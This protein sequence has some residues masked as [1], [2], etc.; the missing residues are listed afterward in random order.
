MGGTRIPRGEAQ[1]L[2]L[3]SATRSTASRNAKRKGPR[4]GESRSAT[5]AFV[6]ASS[7][8]SSMQLRWRVVA[9]THPIGVSTSGSSSPSITPSANR[10]PLSF[11]LPLAG[12]GPDRE[13]HPAVVRGD[14]VGDQLP[15]VGKLDL[16][17]EAP[18]RERAGELVPQV[19]PL[20]LPACCAALRPELAVLCVKAR[21][22]SRSAAS[23]GRPSAP[24]R[25]RAA[26][27]PPDCLRPLR[28]LEVAAQRFATSYTSVE[29]REQLLRRATLVIVPV[30][31][32]AAVLL[33]QLDDLDLP[34]LF[35]SQPSS[36]V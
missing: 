17:I 4:C 26:R 31:L 9:G 8:P 35:P 19:A 2:A 18:Q 16:A 5:A 3:Q 21:C 23:P 11:G 24:C 32:R 10:L 30:G 14:Q 28:Q 1:A 27:P 12:S 15:F 34:L 33:G 20:G 36:P 25:C 13:P 6:H 22:P 7:A 29:V